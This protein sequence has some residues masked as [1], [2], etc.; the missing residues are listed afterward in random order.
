VRVTRLR[1]SGKECGAGEARGV[2]FYFCR[3]QEGIRLDRV[4]SG[5]QHGVRQ[6]G[7]E[8]AKNGI[9]CHYSMHRWSPWL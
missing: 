5:K 1:E 4:A 2:S 8:M 6:V 3:F 9:I 7:F